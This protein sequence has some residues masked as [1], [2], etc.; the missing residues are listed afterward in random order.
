MANKSRAIYGWI[1]VLTCRWR[2]TSDPHA[3]WY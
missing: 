1:A 2:D 3:N